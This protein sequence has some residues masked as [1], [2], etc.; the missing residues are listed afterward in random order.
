MQIRK[1]EAKDEAAFLA[2]IN[3]FYHTEGVLHSVPMSHARATFAAL[4]E[5]SPYVD[6]L[7]AEQD[8]IPVGL[9]MLALTWSNEAGGLTVWIEELYVSDATRGQGVGTALLQAVHCRWPEAKRFRL[10][11]APN[12]EKAAALYATLGYKSLSYGQLVRERK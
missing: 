5:R 2:L 9:A 8:E 12:N 4:M 7:I 6:C 10:E 3:A 1:I 11:V